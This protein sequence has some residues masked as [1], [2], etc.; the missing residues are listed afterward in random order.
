MTRAG[1]DSADAPVPRR[2]L[3][4][5]APGKLL[6]DTTMPLPTRIALARLLARLAARFPAAREVLEAR[7]G[8][9][10]DVSVLKALGT[11][12]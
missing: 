11:R 10:K 8:L 9:E 2:P 12:L 6:Q 3:A 4:G 5:G 1:F 7:I